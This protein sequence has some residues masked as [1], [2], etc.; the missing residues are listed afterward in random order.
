MSLEQRIG[1]A[2]IACVTM[3]ESAFQAVQ[4]D[5]LV[6]AL[7]KAP[8]SVLLEN[9]IAAQ[10]DRHGTSDE[11]ED[12]AHLRAAQLHFLKHPVPVLPENNTAV[13]I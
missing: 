11:R 5:R 1:A 8:R 7:L 6:A 3:G 10:R 9:N 12:S 2:N 4:N 13:D